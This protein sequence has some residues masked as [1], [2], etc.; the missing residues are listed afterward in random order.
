MTLYNV[1]N[2]YSLDKTEEKPVN[3]TVRWYE[4]EIIVSGEPVKV[5][6]GYDRK[7][8]E[9]H[10]LRTNNEKLQGKRIMF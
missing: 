7:H 4:R 2:D 5:E 8:N 10:Y 1:C 6:L 9:L 3:G